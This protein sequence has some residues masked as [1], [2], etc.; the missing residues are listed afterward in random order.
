MTSVSDQLRNQEEEIMRIRNKRNR[1]FNTE[2]VRK[3]LNIA[4]LIVAAIG[5]V[6]YFC[7][8]ENHILGM[9]VIAAGMILKV[10][11][12]FMRIIM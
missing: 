1:K 3:F 8:P 4:F 2:G 12:I 9:V 5:C 6:L 11:E 7:M 10:I